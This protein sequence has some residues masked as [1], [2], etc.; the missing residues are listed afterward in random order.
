MFH[1]TCRA[2][3]PECDL[4]YIKCGAYC[5]GHTLYPLEIPTAPVSTGA[6]CG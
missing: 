4:N 1:H 5:Y 6:K 2:Y 3:V